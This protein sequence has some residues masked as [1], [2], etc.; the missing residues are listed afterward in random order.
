MGNDVKYKEKEII[1]V[2][3]LNMIIFSK[4]THLSMINMAY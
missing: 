4:H 3:I 2:I 1:Y